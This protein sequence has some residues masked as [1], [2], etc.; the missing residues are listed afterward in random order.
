MIYNILYAVLVL[1]TSVILTVIF[2][3]H[4]SNLNYWIIITLVMISNILGR[5]TGGVKHNDC[6]K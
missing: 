4:F 3:L 1:V 5:Y 2:D 6:S